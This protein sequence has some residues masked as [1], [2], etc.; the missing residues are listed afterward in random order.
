[1]VN[2]FSHPITSR[3]VL[4]DFTDAVRRFVVECLRVFVSHGS[5]SVITHPLISSA[6]CCCCF[7]L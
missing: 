7:I 6:F 3:D 4:L 1:M 5:Y 2:P